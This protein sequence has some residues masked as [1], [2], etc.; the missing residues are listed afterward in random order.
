MNP[1]LATVLILSAFTGTRPRESRF[2]PDQLHGQFTLICP[3]KREDIRRQ[4][5]IKIMTQ[6]PG[7]D[8]DRVLR[9]HLGLEESKASKRKGISV[10]TGGV[11][12]AVTGVLEIFGLKTRIPANEAAVTVCEIRSHQ[13]L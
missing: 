3:G 4:G 13:V 10:V 12:D 9:K 5:V 7:F 6:L 8:R 11:N 1:A 2:C